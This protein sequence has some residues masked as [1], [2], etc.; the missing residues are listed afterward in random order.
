VLL[1]QYIKLG[2]SQKHTMDIE[3]NIKSIK[4][5]TESSIESHEDKNLST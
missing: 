2:I 1:K 5:N 3:E 4:E